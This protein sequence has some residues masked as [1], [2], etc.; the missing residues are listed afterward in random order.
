MLP[1]Y[2]SLDV[3]ITTISV[4]LGDFFFL[5]GYTQSID[6]YYSHCIQLN[7]IYEASYTVCSLFGLG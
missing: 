4:L 2:S 7:E 1:L 3:S 5:R 6:L